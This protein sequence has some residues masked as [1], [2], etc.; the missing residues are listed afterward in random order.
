MGRGHGDTMTQHYTHVNLIFC[1][2]AYFALLQKLGS[3]GQH[4]PK[5]S[6]RTVNEPW[7]L[8]VLEG[9]LLVV[10]KCLTPVPTESKFPVLA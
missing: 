5:V 8:H 7:Y 6:L 2:F 4:L 3:G 10:G 1:M 9:R